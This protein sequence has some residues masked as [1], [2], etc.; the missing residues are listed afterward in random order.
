MLQI[1][2]LSINYDGK[3]IVNDLSFLVRHGELVCLQ[4]N[5]GCGKTSILN[6]IMGFTP[7]TGSI[8]MDGKLLNESTVDELRR[9]VAYVPQELALPQQTVR[10]MVYLPYQLKANRHSQPSEDTVF[11]E[12]KRLNLDASLMDMSASAISGGQRQRIMLSVAGL[13]GKSLMLVDEPT[14]ALDSDNV[15]LVLDYFRFLAASR[16]MA[17]LVASH[18]QEIISGCDM[19]V[20]IEGTMNHKTRESHEYGD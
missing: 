20:R 15:Q 16:N 5:S 17:I 9:L 10:E 12:W 4:G 1:S 7:Y 3:S 2:N 6:C 14:S 18:H 8:T 11:E 19:V 13:L